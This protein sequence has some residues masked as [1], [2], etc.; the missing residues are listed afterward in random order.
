MHNLT[1][2]LAALA[3]I[4]ATATPAM[5]AERHTVTLADGSEISYALALP[6]GF[7]PEA[8]Y[9]ALLAIPGGE[10]TIE[11][12]LS[13]VERSFEAEAGKR[14]YIV[15]GASTEYNGVRPMFGPYA[16]DTLLPQFMD[17]LLKLYH[18]EDGR[19]YLAGHSAGG[20][21]V[22]RIGVR[23]PEMFRS[24]TSMSSYAGDE[25]LASLPAL[26]GLPVNMFVGEMDTAYHSGAAQTRDLLL[27]AGVDVYFEIVAGAAHSLAPLRAQE[28]QVFLFDK[29]T[30]TP[31]Q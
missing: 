15:F 24:L 26:K 17:A 23:H 2:R 25:D 31:G 12:A 21:T 7:N 19:F 9:P 14:G 27:A 16:D 4:A 29:I 6:P 1:H 8:S 10:Q 3:L 11:G 22:F 13:I 5:A 30:G 20:E 18:I 28:G